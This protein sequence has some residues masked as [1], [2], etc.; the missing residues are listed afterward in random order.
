MEHD[1]LLFAVPSHTED[2]LVK[3]KRIGEP[4]DPRVI[5][6]TQDYSAGLPYDYICHITLATV[7][8]WV[9][10]SSNKLAI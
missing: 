1:Y 10:N 9:V 5:I 2:V 4:S 3:R 8:L 7:A 6:L